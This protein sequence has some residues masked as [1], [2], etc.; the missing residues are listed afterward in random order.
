[1]IDT[2]AHLSICEPDDA[3]LVAAAREAGAADPH[4]GLDEASNREAIA[5][6]ERHEEVFA[7]IGSPPEL[8]FGLRRGRGGR[9][10]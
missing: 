9:R 3:D 4:V 8:G 2:D 7:G 6:A 1:M 5:A 10:Q